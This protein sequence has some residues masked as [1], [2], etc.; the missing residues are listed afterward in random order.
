MIKKK[1]KFATDIYKP[2]INTIEL[3]YQLTSTNY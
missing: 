3:C 2:Q 1:T